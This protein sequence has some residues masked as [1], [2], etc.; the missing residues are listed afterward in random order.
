MVFSCPASSENQYSLSAYFF[1][2]ARRQSHGGG[3]NSR[4]LELIDRDFRFFR[5]H[6]RD[7]VADRIDPFTRLAFEPRAIGHEFYS[8]FAKWAYQNIQQILSYS[9][10]NGSYRGKSA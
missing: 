3:L 6:Y 5:E 1:E 2:Q 9:H 8:S 10:G 4:I 7:I